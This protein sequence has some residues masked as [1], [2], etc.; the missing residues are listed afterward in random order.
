MSLSSSDPRLEWLEERVSLAL[1]TSVEDFKYLLHEK[2]ADVSQQERFLADLDGSLY[3]LT[4]FFSEEAKAGSAIFFFPVV[5]E[6]EEEY[7]AQE[8]VTV[9][10][11]GAIS[12][13]A[14]TERDVSEQAS[15]ADGQSV[16]GVESETGAE[17]VAA[18]AASIQQ[19]EI[20]AAEETSVATSN[21]SGEQQQATAENPQAAAETTRG[22]N[23]TGEG[24]DGTGAAPTGAGEEEASS[25]SGSSV[26]GNPSPPQDAVHITRTV[27]KRRMINLRR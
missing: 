21:K 23:P 8:D 6:I 1:G 9:H 27:V 2:G 25:T 5:E 11:A 10:S 22:N 13:A 15:V 12:E 14:A 4:R 26:D 24:Q 17:N 16:T 20:N 18:I 19:G 3:T 7:E